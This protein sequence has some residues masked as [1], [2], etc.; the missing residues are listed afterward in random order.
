MLA[1]V[2]S[3]PAHSLEVRSY[4]AQRH[5]RFLNFP[6]APEM[7]PNFLYGTTD[8]TGVGWYLAPSNTTVERRRQYTLVSPKHFVGANHFPP[9]VNGQ[10][11][12]LG[13]D[14]V[15]RTYEIASVQSVPNPN[16]DAS[17]LLL[18]TL[19]TEVDPG[20]GVNFQPFLSVL[21]P[22]YIGQELIFMGHRRS[23]NPTLRAGRAVLQARSQFGEGTAVGADTGIERTETFTWTYRESTILNTGNPDDSFTEPG[24][25]G[26]P[27]LAIID[28][29]GALVGTH[30]A[31]GSASLLISSQN[32]SYDTFVPFYVDGMNEIMATEGYHMTRAV[33]GPTKP[34][35]TLALET[36]LPGII[37]AGY[38]VSL[39][40]T[41]TNEGSAEDANNLR[42]SI[43]LP[44]SNDRSFSGSEWISSVEG[45][46][47]EARKGGLNTGEQT[48]MT[49]QFTPI[50][51]GTFTSTVAY[52]A[53]EFAET[54]EELEFEIIESFR[55]WSAGLSEGDLSDDPDRDGISN[56]QEYAFGGDPEEPGLSSPGDGEA[57]L[58][59]VE[60]LEDGLVF[61]H[62]QR[63]DAAARALSYLV[64]VSPDLSD[65]SWE[66]LEPSAGQIET[67]PAGDGFERI[68]I[69]LDETAG[70]GF[71][72]LRV[73]LDE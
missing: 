10:L 36:S 40:A 39:P 70:A 49:V 2:I 30:T 1:L 55:S 28:G 29:Q 32:I 34:T 54:S 67:T 35:T 51:P 47:F 25:S 11:Q 5:D 60:M 24:D 33:P 27:S 22:Q 12:F 3:Q 45:A 64:E 23:G 44:S 58:P 50:S 38:P 53:D 43:T 16:G 41:L 8:L 7:N 31:A 56:L 6:S 48:A 26:S 9:S 18:G 21:D 42:F 52:S 57:L 17:D 61:N 71:Y 63:T 65:G 59:T 72:R 62:L 37:R 46:G 13:Q 20:V 73:E 68:R 14:G 4:S 19:E 15:V 66:T 69:R